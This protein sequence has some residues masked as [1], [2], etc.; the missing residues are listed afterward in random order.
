VKWP[1]GVA[2]TLDTGAYDAD[3]IGLRTTDGGATWFGYVEGAL[4]PLDNPAAGGTFPLLWL[5]PNL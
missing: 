3:L 1:S 4:Y 2:P 5:N